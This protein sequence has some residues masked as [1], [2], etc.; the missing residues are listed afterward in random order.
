MNDN[1]N[2]GKSMSKESQIQDRSL[3][4]E[5]MLEELSQR[6]QT[7]EKQLT[8]QQSND[9]NN[10]LTRKR[11]PVKSARTD[12]SDDENALEIFHELVDNF[13]VDYFVVKPRKKG[14][15]SN[16]FGRYIFRFFFP[17]SSS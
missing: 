15:G 11:N 4:I 5:R 8:D 17:R 7:I 14:D 12:D 16:S 6:I 10:K 3:E 13:S 9:V 1:S 2:Q